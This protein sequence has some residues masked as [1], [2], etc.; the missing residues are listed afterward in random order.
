MNNKSIRKMFGRLITIHKDRSPG[1]G[2]DWVVM[3]TSDFGEVAIL[4][5]FRV[6]KF[7]E[8]YRKQLI[9]NLCAL[10]EKGASE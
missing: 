3:Y 4:Q 1:Y 7:A 10:V 8:K 9:D 2:Q 5:R 6:G